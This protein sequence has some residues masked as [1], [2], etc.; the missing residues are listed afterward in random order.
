[1]GSRGCFFDV[2]LRIQDL[3][4]F[5]LSKPY[6]NLQSLLFCRV[7]IKSALGNLKRIY[8]EVGF[9]RLRSPLAP[10]FRCFGLSGLRPNALAPEVLRL[11]E[12]A[13]S[14]QNALGL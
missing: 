13:E 4:L 11:A 9:G 14:S 10:N 7:P 3:G 2:R 6:F 12:A 5:G 1:M 8:K